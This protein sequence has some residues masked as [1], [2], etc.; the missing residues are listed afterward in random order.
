MEAGKE[1]TSSLLTKIYTDR[2]S[3]GGYAGADALY[4]EAKRRNKSITRAQVEHF[5]EG[6]RTYGLFK[7]RRLRFPR[8]KTFAAGYF[9]D[10]QAD[11]AGRVRYPRLRLRDRLIREKFRFPKPGEQESGLSIPAGASGHSKPAGLRSP[12][13]NKGDSGHDRGL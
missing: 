13:Q 8:S 2:A 4:R 1:V 11:L 10:A 6:Q 9:T 7:P 3:P 12:H 5:L